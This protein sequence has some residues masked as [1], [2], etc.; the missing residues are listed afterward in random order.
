MGQRE[1]YQ[2]ITNR[3]INE[4]K[5]GSLPW[6]RVNTQDGGVPFNYVTGK[7]Y[8]GINKLLLTHGGAY[9]TLNQIKETGAKFISS[10]LTAAELD[11]WAHERWSSASHKDAEKLKWWESLSH[12][13]RE[14]FYQKTTKAESIIFYAIV[15]SKKGK[16][17][18]AGD[19]AE[20]QVKSGDRYPVLRMYEVYSARYLTGLVQHKDINKNAATYGDVDDVISRYLTSTGV[21]VV[22]TDR[23]PMYDSL[24]DTLSMRSVKT[25]RDVEEYYADYFH[26]L[27]HSTGAKSRLDRNLDGTYTKNDDNYKESIIAEMASAMVCGKLQLD[28]EKAFNATVAQINGWIQALSEDVYFCVRAASRSEKAARFILEDYASPVTA[29]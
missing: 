1:Y 12:D 10:G 2:S 7:P 23:D 19:S 9:L 21:R 16:P 29:N 4:L 24:S 8:N 27:A 18:D 11:D 22:P 3:I 14:Q 17:K 28:T 5:S 6:V 26:G 25:Y 15:E 20:P 13:D